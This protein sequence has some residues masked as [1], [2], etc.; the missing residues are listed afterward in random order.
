MCTKRKLGKDKGIKRN[1]DSRVQKICNWDSFIILDEN[2]ETLANFL[3]T[4]LSQTYQGNPRKELVLSGG[5]SHPMKVCS[6]TE[7]D[8]EGVA[9]DHEEADTRIILQARD[10]NIRGYQQVNI[11]CQD[12][13]VLVLLVAHLPNISPAVW[14][15]TGTA[16]KK[17]Y[18][19][20]HQIRISEEKRS[21]C[22]PSMPSPAVTPLA[23]SLAL[24]NSQLGECLPHAHG[25]LS[26][27]VK[28]KIQ[29][30]RSSPMVK[31]SS[32]SFTIVEQRPS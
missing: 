30:A 28:I 9:S 25:Y 31:P 18:I 16:K 5:F 17:L 3:C 20:V 6:S 24:G 23:S 14:M 1:V 11:M 2:K 26:I 13:D 8:L 4:T 12:T 10:A 29:M 15:F 27:L 22:Y 21:S 32:V 19:P 7:R